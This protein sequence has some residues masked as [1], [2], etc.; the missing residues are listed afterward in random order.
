MVLFVFSP[1]K[2]EIWNVCLTLTYPLLGVK[3]SS[4]LKINY[5]SY[6][7]NLT[8]P[9]PAWQ[10]QKREGEGEGEGGGRKA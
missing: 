2:N 7:S 10:V 5:G 6:Q 9:Q 1:S 4:D 8:S 3:G